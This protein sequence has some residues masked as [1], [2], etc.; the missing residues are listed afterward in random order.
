MAWTQAQYDAG[1][2]YADSRKNLAVSGYA[3]AL[4]VARSQGLPDPE[5]PRGLSSQTATQVFM[6]I[7]RIQNA[8]G[9]CSQCG[10]SMNAAER[11]LG[12]VCGA[13]CRQNHRQAVAGR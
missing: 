6:A 12:P 4:V 1:M 13:C 7:T 10:G 11:M 8:A 9:F 2:K 3:A 5:A